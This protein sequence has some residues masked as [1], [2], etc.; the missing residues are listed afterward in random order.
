MVASSSS[1]YSL[2]GNMLKP[3]RGINMGDGWE[4]IRNRPSTDDGGKARTL[5]VVSISML[6]SMSLAVVAQCSA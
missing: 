1:H 5:L 4:T 6:M 2:P 3:G